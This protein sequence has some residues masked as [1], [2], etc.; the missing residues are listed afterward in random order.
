MVHLAAAVLI[1]H[2]G[3]VDASQLAQWG[4]DALSVIRRD[5]YMPDRKLYGEEIVSGQPPKQVSFNWGVGVMLSA[6]NAAAR[7]DKQYDPWLRE[8]ADASHSYWNPKGPVPGYDVLPGPKDADRYYDDNEWMVMSLVE[9]Y[10][11]LHDPKYLHWA[12]ET[13]KFV[14]SG[15]S[16]DLGG[17]IFWKEAE[18]NSKNTCSNAPGAAACLAVYRHTHDPALLQKARELYAWTKRTLMDP[19]DHLFYDN[20]GLN[21]HIAKDKWSYNVAL[22]IRTA[23]NLYA[24]NKQPSYKADIEAMKKSSVARFI[25][26]GR[27]TDPGRFAHLLQESWTFGQRDAG[28]QTSYAEVVEP[29]VNLHEHGMSSTGLYP[30]RW[31]SPAPGPDKKVALLDQASAVRAMFTAAEYLRKH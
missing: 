14:L 8:F 17:G 25:R 13:L 1:A 20:I 2:T 22:M 9:T 7:Y 3:N 31:N 10:E 16:S 18:K 6:L 12:Q 23:S 26:D 4:K 21:G 30:D 5:F 27:F 11:H 15:E 28:V 19:S 29:M 24:L